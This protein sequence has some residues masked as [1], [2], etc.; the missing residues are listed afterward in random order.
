MKQL[1]R[2]IDYKRLDISSDAFTH[3]G[4]IPEKYSCLGKDI[5]PSLEIEGIPAEAVSLA[6]IMHDP[7]A[8]AG[9]WVHWLVWNIPVTHHIR[10]NHVPGIEGLND[11]HKTCYK[12]PCPPE[13]THRYIFKVY[14]LDAILDLTV[15]SSRSQLEKAMSEHIVG[16][17]EMTGLFS[18][19]GH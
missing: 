5:S 10:E 8:P 7:D 14:A 2:A 12:G 15:G 4:R 11:F 16:Y 9:D 13:G 6:V 3:N 17:G 19:T 1:A 18:R